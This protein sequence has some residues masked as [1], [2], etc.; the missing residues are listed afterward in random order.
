MRSRALTLLALFIIAS[1]GPMDMLGDS[2]SFGCLDKPAG[3]VEKLGCR[4][5]EGDKADHCWQDAAVR[6]GDSAPC[7]NIERGPPM[8]KCFMRVAMR[9]EDPSLCSKMKDVPGGYSPS[10]C[11]YRTAASLG[12]K[13]LCNKITKPKSTWTGTFSKQTCLENI[14]ELESQYDDYEPTKLEDDVDP[15]ISTPCETQMDCKPVCFGDTIV[16]R[17]CA[18]DTCVE[19]HR[20]DCSQEDYV[21]NTPSYPRVHGRVHPRSCVERAHYGGEC[22]ISNEG[23]N[24]VVQDAYDVQLNELFELRNKYMED[25][26]KL[27]RTEEY[28]DEVNAELDKVNKAIE[29]VNAERRKFSRVFGQAYA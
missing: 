4:F 5:M 12:D 15:K 28:Y 27:G 18:G 14:E 22:T 1:C 8:D 20:R 2:P 13:E 17:M 7:Y 19:S 29:E 21:M 25:L 9:A 24:R 16:E 6:M 23:F 10:E 26:Q 11:Y 3:V